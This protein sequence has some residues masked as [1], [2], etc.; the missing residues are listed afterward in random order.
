M[1]ITLDDA[2]EKLLRQELE[3]G[4]YH[5][6]SEVIARALMV[7]ATAEDWLV[8]NR[9]AVNERLDESFAQAARDEGYSPD[10]AQAI[11]ARRKA[12]RAA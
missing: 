3:R 7:L 4:I 12:H 10:E 6:P 8:R 5:E 2:T 9:D 1:T 11:L